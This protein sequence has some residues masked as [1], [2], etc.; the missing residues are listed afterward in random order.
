MRDELKRKEIFLYSSHSES[1]QERKPANKQNL[2]GLMSQIN[3]P[4]KDLDRSDN[5]TKYVSDKIFS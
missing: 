5:F 1:F 4:K 2:S 3:L